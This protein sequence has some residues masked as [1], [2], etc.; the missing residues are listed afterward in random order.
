MQVFMTKTCN[1]VEMVGGLGQS[2][3]VNHKVSLLITAAGQFCDQRADSVQVAIACGRPL[4]GCVTQ[5]IG[6]VCSVE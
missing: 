5:L 1:Q 2:N 3:L 4:A 6:L